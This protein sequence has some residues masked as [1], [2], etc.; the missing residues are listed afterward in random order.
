MLMFAANRLRTAFIAVTACSSDQ[1]RSP[2]LF[3]NVYV[4]K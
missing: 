4:S 3:T 1:P 2:K